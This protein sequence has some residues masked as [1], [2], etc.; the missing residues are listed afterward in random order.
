MTLTQL[1][2]CSSAYFLLVFLIDMEMFMSDNRITHLYLIE[3][4][5]SLE[6][7]VRSKSESKRAHFEKK[8]QL[9]PRDRLA[10]LLDPAS[11]WIEF[12]TLAGLNMHDDKASGDLSHDP[13]EAKEKD[14]LVQAPIAPLGGGSI[15]GL[16][17]VSG[18]RVVIYLSLIHI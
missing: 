14:T 16:G 3:Q 2:E 7:A 1:D 15:A 10:Y 12:S 11:E 17:W 9:T 18:L 8:N 5:R 4:I 13:S 6:K